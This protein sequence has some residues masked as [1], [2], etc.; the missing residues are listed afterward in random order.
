M[1]FL[2]YGKGGGGGFRLDRWIGLGRER[3]GLDCFWEFVA[4]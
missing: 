3:E 2:S 1:F 4:H